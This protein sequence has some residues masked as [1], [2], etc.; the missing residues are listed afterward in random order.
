MTGRGP[1]GGSSHRSAWR[2]P[3]PGPRRRGAG[4]GRDQGPGHGGGA[5]VI[6]RRCAPPVAVRA[7]IAGTP[8]DTGSAQR[9]DASSAR[10]VRK[11][12]V[13]VARTSGRGPR[14]SLCVSRV[15][16]RRRMTPWVRAGILSRVPGNGVIGGPRGTA[17]P[18]VD[19]D[20]G[21][22]ERA[23]RGELV[24]RR[25]LFGRLRAVSAGGAAARRDK[26][27]RGTGACGRRV[28]GRAGRPRV[29]AGHRREGRPGRRGWPRPDPG[30]VAGPVGRGTAVRGTRVRAALRHPRGMRTSPQGL[31]GI[32]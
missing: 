8:Q 11:D 20:P 10:R 17:E 16:A 30:R 26:G 23:A 21:G 28:A 1:V 14:G 18:R 25:A 5:C 27:S 22:R 7:M 15:V 32:P 24:L 29:G 9:H 3:A 6:R 19:K 13:E 31:S 4:A 2:A 12:L